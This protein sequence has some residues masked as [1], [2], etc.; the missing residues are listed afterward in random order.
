MGS[1]FHAKNVKGGALTYCQTDYAQS[2]FDPEKDTFSFDSHTKEGTILKLIKAK[3]PFNKLMGT[4]LQNA[5][6]F[7]WNRT[8]RARN[9]FVL[10]V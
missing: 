3:L 5:W 2:Q 8:L 4:F 10:M 7:R 6:K 9:S 1:Y